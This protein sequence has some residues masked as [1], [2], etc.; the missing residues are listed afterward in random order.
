METLP[1]QSPRPI[2]NKQKIPLHN[3]IGLCRDMGVISSFPNPLVTAGHH[4]AGPEPLT[5]CALKRPS[6]WSWL[7]SASL[8]NYVACVLGFWV[9][10]FRY[11]EHSPVGVFPP[12]PYSTVCGKAVALCTE[13]L[14]RLSAHGVRLRVV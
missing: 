12:N 9:Y 10:G 1:L 4:K 6:D 5:R 11:A 3:S 13:C 8:S 14:A 7:V 2:M